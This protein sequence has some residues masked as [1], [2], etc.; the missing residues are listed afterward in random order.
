MIRALGGAQILD[1]RRTGSLDRRD[2]L[3]QPTQ[4]KDK[5]KRQ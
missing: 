3:S 5:G 4:D 1:Y 2:S